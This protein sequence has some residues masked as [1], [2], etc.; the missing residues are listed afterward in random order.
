MSVLKGLS[1]VSF[2][3]TDWKRAKKFYGETLGLPVSFDAGE[4]VGWCEFGE[5]GKTTLAIS[6]WRESA[7]PPREGGATPVFDVGDAHKAVEELRKR[8]VK[9]DDVVTIPDM[10]AF[11]NVY[12]P[13][14]NR[15][16]VA[17]SLAAGQ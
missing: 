2:E 13:E 14:G 1:V 11:A 9:C 10:V 3:V 5:T 8:G 6:L 16:Q 7:P 17:Q 4:E 12:D 15:F